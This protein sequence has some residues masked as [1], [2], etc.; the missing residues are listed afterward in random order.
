MSD[1]QIPL[2]DIYDLSKNVTGAE[3]N[4]GFILGLER[5]MLFFITE[6][7][8]DKATIQP[9]FQKFEKLLNGA[10]AEDHPFTEM[11]AHV[12]TL[13]ALQQLLR[14]LAFEQ[15]LIKKSETTV[16]AD[17]AKELFK[18]YLEKNPEKVQEFM[19]KLANEDSSR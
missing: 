7:I 4:T 19:S 17:E 14:S 12:Y 3:I 6:V 1:K 16:S 9:M 15:N 8:Q 2:A 5:V 11:E 18:A 10:K 13:F